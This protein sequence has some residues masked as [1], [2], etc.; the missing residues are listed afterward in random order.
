MRS[1]SPRARVLTRFRVTRAARVAAFSTLS[2]F[3]PDEE[4]LLATGDTADPTFASRQNSLLDQSDRPSRVSLLPNLLALSLSLSLSLS[5]DLLKLCDAK[6]HPW[7]RTCFNRKQ[8]AAL[9]ATFS[10]ALAPFLLTCNVR[11]DKRRGRARRLR[12]AAVYFC[13][14][15]RA[16]I[17]TNGRECD[18]RVLRALTQ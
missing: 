4:R 5:L 11:A 3:R 17:K 18:A 2:L 10:R 15:M 7:G 14:L 12:R 6:S 13:R 8:K 9:L 16:L 1:T